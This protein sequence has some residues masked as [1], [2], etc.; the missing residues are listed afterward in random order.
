MKPS[1]TIKSF[2]VLAGLALAG[3]AVAQ[4]YTSS[5]RDILTP[6]TGTWPAGGVSLNG[7]PFVVKG[8]QGVGRIAAS[9]I[10][11]ATGESLGSISDMQIT[12]FATGNGL[13]DTSIVGV[14]TAIEADH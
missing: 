9:T 10:D 3:P 8:L 12:N 6:N 5:N 7:T 13:L 2:V 1:L 14:E 4:P 11:S